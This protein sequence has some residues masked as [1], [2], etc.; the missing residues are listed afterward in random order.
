MAQFV[1]LHVHT[2]YSLLD[3]LSKIPQLVAKAKEYGMPALAITDHGSMYGAIA[4]YNECIKA[5]IKP[6][7]GCEVYVA[8]KSRFDKEIRTEADKPTHLVLLAKNQIGYRNLLRLVTASNLEGYYYKPRIDDELL[9]QHHEGLIALSA[10]LQGEIARYIRD[11]AGEKAK[12]RALF[13]RDLFG[14]G[15]YYLEIQKHQIDIQDQVNEGIIAL[16]QELSI[17]LIAT[18][19]VHYINKDDAEAQEVLLCVQTQKT[20]L[21][22]NRPLSMID[23]PDFYLR[24]PEEMELLFR[25]TPEAVSNSLRIAES[26][27]L[28]IETGKM[29]FP[30]F[31]IPNDEKEE[32]YFHMLVMTKAREKLGEITEEIDKRLSY[33]MGIIESK[34][35]IPYFL[36]VGDFVNWAKDQGIGVGPGRG[37]AAGSLVSYVM[38]ITTINPLEYKLPFERF[39]NPERPTPPDIDMD[40][41]DD[42]RDEVVKYITDKYG[43]DHVAQIITFGTMEARGSIR[44]VGRVLGMPYSDPD[45]IAKL[46]PFGSSID[47]ALE[48]VSELKDA[49]QDQKFKRLLDLARKLEGVSRHASTHAAGLVISDKPLVDYVPLQRESKGEKIITQYDMYALD[50]N[51]SENAIGL[52]KMDLLGL[53]NLSILARAIAIVKSTRNI[54]VDLPAIPLDDAS[55]YQTIASGDT[56]GVFQMESAGMR[57]LAKD[58]N[59]NRFSDLV[60]MVALFRPGP[61]DL[62]PQFIAGKKNPK[63]IHYPHDDLKD[64]LEDTY[65]VLIY[66]EQCLYVANRIAGFSMGAADKLRKAIGKKKREIMEKEKIKFLDGAVKLGYQKKVSEELWGFIEKFAGYGFNKAH[67]ASYAMIAYQTAFLKTHYP[68]EYMCA[69]FS[70]ENSDKD[71]IAMLVG[72]CRKAKI[73]VLAPDVNESDFDFSIQEGNIRFGLTAIKN[74]GEGAVSNIILVRTEGKF[75]SLFDFCRRVDLHAI[76][77]KVLESL[78]R[79][80]AFDSFGKRAAQLAALEQILD[81]SHRQKQQKNAGMLGL[82]DGEESSESIEEMA[83]PDIEEADNRQKLAWERELLG[84][85]LSE[86]PLYSYLRLLGS[87]RTHTIRDLEMEHTVGQQAKVGIV[88]SDIRKI[89]TK[90][91]NHEMAFVKAEDETGSLEIIVFPKIY[92]Q[93]KDLWVKDQILIVQGKVDVKDEALKIIADSAKKVLTESLETEKQAEEAEHRLVIKLPLNTNHENL[94][95]VYDLLKQYPGEVKTFLIF[96]NA[97]DKRTME[98]PFRVDDN[99]ELR[100][101]LVDLLGVQAL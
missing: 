84:F 15:N 16:A 95:G 34:G 30:R 71:K 78:I 47:E 98:L 7:I 44:D 60:A 13:Y 17:P 54:D 91:N 57:R 66:Q 68:T 99:P 9:L 79:S 39:L 87:R 10:C 6:I 94:Y 50:L 80:G 67:S 92:A 58:L 43:V 42:R 19:D 63:K 77:K 29:F 96:S 52:L 81:R 93:S 75:T 26:I 64:I 41:A 48:S 11:N 31:P 20:L 83:L 35:Y 46:I 28:T 3:G 101:R 40:F 97:D 38:N 2:E 74:V 4:F 69:L 89:F 55:V 90:A 5:D 76:N 23:S 27:N 100:K 33:E 51:V 36:V 49:Y 14:E 22:K 45:K 37:S 88:I 1:H 72:E 61:M 12:N 56:T 62:I 18:N 70:A 73:E 32:T 21:E 86:H 8:R 53:R 65:G 85:Y 82:F 25:D 59:P 24:S